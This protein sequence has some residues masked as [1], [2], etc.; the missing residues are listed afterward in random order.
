MTQDHSA[1]T[2][3]N[4]PAT[5]LTPE[6]F[7]AAVERM[8]EPRPLRPNVV[9]TS[10]WNAVRLDVAGRTESWMRVRKPLKLRLR[11][12]WGALRIERDYDETRVDQLRW[13]WR[14]FRENTH[15]VFTPEAT[16]E[17]QWRFAEMGRSTNVG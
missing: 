8:M 17:I 4:G 5:A 11:S 15:S 10:R 13:A 16:R 7:M 14:R 2:G 12:A 9:V 1:N 6:L 3:A